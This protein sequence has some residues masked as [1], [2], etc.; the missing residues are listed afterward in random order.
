MTEL[1]TKDGLLMLNI[2]KKKED[3][4]LDKFWQFESGM[5]CIR[6]TERGSVANHH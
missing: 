5:V 1:Q 2:G 6:L 4:R 3:L